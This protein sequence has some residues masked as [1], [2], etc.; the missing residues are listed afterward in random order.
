[1]NILCLVKLVPDV[2][3]FKYDYERNVLIRSGVHQVINPEDATALALALSIKKEVPETSIETVTMAPKGAIVHLEDLIRRGVDTATLLSDSTFVGSDTYVTSRI[4]ARYI[5]STT[6]DCIFA[7]THTLDGGTA[8]VPAQI[9]EILDVPHLSQIVEI[10]GGALSHGSTTVDVD[11]ETNTLT[12]EV[13]LPAILSFAYSTKRKL[14]Y[15][16]FEDMERDVSRQIKIVS[17][18]TLRFVGSELGITGSPT[19]VATA[20]AKTLERKDTVTVGTDDEGVETVYQFLLR[21]G[22]LQR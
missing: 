5:E 4:L 3:N 13:D 22:F 14:P 15:I 21:K 1:M 9:A 11:G 17:N 20:E 16:A 10:D 7:G 18:D 2:E 6:F 12:F 8:H 19:A